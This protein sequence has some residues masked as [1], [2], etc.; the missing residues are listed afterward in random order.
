MRSK[1]STNILFLTFL[2]LILR[3]AANGETFD[4]LKKLESNPQGF[5]IRAYLQDLKG[6]KNEIQ[7]P[8]D[9][10]SSSTLASKNNDETQEKGKFVPRRRE[11]GVTV[12]PELLL[13]EMASLSK[14]FL[15]SEIKNNLVAT[16]PA[17]LYLALGRFI[18]LTNEDT[19]SYIELTGKWKL[20]P[21]KSSPRNLAAFDMYL[22]KNHIHSVSLLYQSPALK[23]ESLELRNV[24]SESNTIFV[25][26]QNELNA[27]VNEKTQG[28]IKEVALPALT[29]QVLF[30]IL[31]FKFGWYIKFNRE[32]ELSDFYVAGG[33]KKQLSYASVNGIFVTAGR[34]SNDD[35]IAVKLDFVKES[36][37]G[38]QEVSESERLEDFS[39]YLVLSKRGKPLD[40]IWEHAHRTLSRTKAGE[41]VVRFP[42]FRTG[43]HMEFSSSMFPSL[44]RPQNT[45]FPIFAQAEGKDSL[46]LKIYQQTLICV[47]ENGSLG[48]GVTAISSPNQSFPPHLEFNQPF[49]YIIAANKVATPL[50][51]SYVT[52]GMTNVNDKCS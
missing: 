9:S 33:G 15:S 37:T 7:P 4:L 45:D 11:D 35:Y 8:R 24:L 50:F 51:V 38:R 12:T 44:L 19:D 27:K 14:V 30:N 31:H 18:D 34:D 20:N 6:L 5:W 46:D 39:A 2:V 48:G 13:E 42:A 36:A 40:E 1:I 41:S 28:G 49:Y 47:D 43:Q 23:G 21:E 3:H 16:S 17:G 22:E 52:D 29:N 25:S 26:S 32:E 10:T